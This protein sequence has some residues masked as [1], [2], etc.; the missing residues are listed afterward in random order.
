MAVCAFAKIALN[1]TFTPLYPFDTDLEARYVYF[2]DGDD[3]VL[4][5]EFDIG[6]FFRSTSLEIRQA[7]SDATGVPVDRIL[8]HEH[9]A[10]SAPT[11]TQWVGEPAR[12]VAEKSIAALKP[13]IESA[14]ECQVAWVVA[15]VGDEFS[16]V[17]EQY[18]PDVGGVTNWGDYDFAE[19]G[20]AHTEDTGKLL[21]AG[22]K[23][24]VPALNEPLYFD[25][26][27]DT[28]VPLLVFRTPEGKA[29]GSVC[30]FAAHVA[31]VHYRKPGGDTDYHYS[32]DWPGY[33]RGRLE[34]EFGGMGL[35]LNG[36]CGDLIPKMRCGNTFEEGRR[37][38]QR[39]GRGVAERAIA[40]FNSGGSAFEPLRLQG[41]A[42]RTA[43]L[44][45]RDTI[46]RSREELKD[47]PD[48]IEAARAELNR[49]IEEGAWPTR[50]KRQVD[51]LQHLGV[52]DRFVEKWINFSDDEMAR[53][54]MT[55]DVE[56]LGLNGLVFVGLPGEALT[57]TGQWV[58]SQTLGERV[59]T[60]DQ[61]NGYCVYLVTRERYDLGGYA[62]W[63]SVL[64]R[65]SEPLL[66]K[67][68]V[69]AVREV[70]LSMGR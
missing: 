56:A 34:E 54:V 32:W 7:L 55:V 22:W 62:Y 58:R 46:P 8:L 36:P 69:D 13:A 61:V 33:L 4:I 11:A 47:M 6:Y 21:L 30:R 2:R 44:P 66:R 15:D 24:D 59:V 65:D 29:I 26:P 5:G 41:F 64:A 50:I 25:R 45:L 28:L 37:E 51:L 43:E 18:L 68:A 48:R 60:I 17:R 31:I 49:L 14:Q 67:T 52:M 39:I 23:P 9:Q 35:C 3:S 63:C 20:R 70:A 10:H 1:D 27:T 16:H 53:R 40:E 57:D 19:D 42:K 12:K 38:S